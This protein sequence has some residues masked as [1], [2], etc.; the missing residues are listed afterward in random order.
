MQLPFFNDNNFR[1]LLFVRLKHIRHRLYMRT[2]IIPGWPVIISD[3][4]HTTYREDRTTVV[5]RSVDILKN[6]SQWSRNDN[7]RIKFLQYEYHVEGDISLYNTLAQE[8][9]RMLR[10]YSIID[11]RVR[12]L[13]YMVK[14]FAKICGSAVPSSSSSARRFEAIG[15]WIDCE[16]DA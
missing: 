13:G 14:L 6:L 4:D 3:Y 9:T 10:L 16:H 12:I 15:T 8:N 1:L 11:V 5:L 2:I 7:W